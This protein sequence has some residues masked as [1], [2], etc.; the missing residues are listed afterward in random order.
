[1]PVPFIL[2]GLAVLAGAAGVAEAV[3]AHDKMG[4]A[5][6][7]NEEAQE[8]V[9]NASERT[10]QARILSSKSIENLGRAKL[11]ICSTSM[12]MFVKNFRRIKNVD[13]RDSVGMEEL[14]G[15]TPNSE[16]MLQ[17][18][19]ATF[20][21]SDIASGGMGGVAAGT[22]MAAG[23]YGAVGMLGAASTGAA[24]SG[25]SGAAATNA[26]LAWLGGGSLASGGLGMAG[27]MAVLGGLVAGP[28]LAVTG[29][30]MNS[31]AEEAWAKARENLDKAW[32]FDEQSKNIEA[33][34]NGISK[35]ADQIKDILVKLENYFDD[36]NDA[37]LDVMLDAGTDWKNY[38]V[39]Q[40]KTVGGCAQLAKTI[41]IILDTSLLNEA[42]DDV[43]NESAKIIEVGN[44]ALLEQGIEK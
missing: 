31:K 37:L 41:K 29:F 35:R 19:Q 27:G 39:A 13:F 44:N 34:L 20:K 30:F 23:S 6:E 21:A 16:E 42:G 26:T 5:K 11:D 17:M 32:A 3:D 9:A 15:F 36:A 38:S 2:G 22:L 43:S 1:M 40:K 14:A 25:L 24:I 4:Y 8:I 12:K 10:E 28:A 18:E 33:R 7:D